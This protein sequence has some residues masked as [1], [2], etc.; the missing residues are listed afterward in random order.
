MKV[1]IVNV[2]SSTWEPFWPLIDSY[3]KFVTPHTSNY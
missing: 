1:V 2:G 3:T